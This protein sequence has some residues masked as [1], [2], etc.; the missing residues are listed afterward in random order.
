MNE[1]FS[2]IDIFESINREISIAILNYF[3]VLSHLS[4]FQSILS[5]M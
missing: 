4:D 3:N 2:N 5:V 1:N